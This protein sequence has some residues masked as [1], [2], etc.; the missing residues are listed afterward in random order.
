MPEAVE[1][2][3]LMVPGVSSVSVDLVWEP[4][5]E[6]EMMSESARRDLGWN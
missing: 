3:L 6:P 2:A 5:W 4:R 1:R